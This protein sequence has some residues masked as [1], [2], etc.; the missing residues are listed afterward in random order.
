MKDYMI[1]LEMKD[2]HRTYGYFKYECQ[3]ANFYNALITA[4]L[5]IKKLEMQMVYNYEI[6]KIERI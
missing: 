2:A 1:L 5:R 4:E 3:A 6:I